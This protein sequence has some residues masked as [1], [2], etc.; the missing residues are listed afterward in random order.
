MFSRCVYIHQFVVSFIFEFRKKQGLS[1]LSQMQDCILCD[2]QGRQLVIAQLVE[3]WT[4]E[5]A[6]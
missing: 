3:R 4:V 5:V 1:C 2:R 6:V